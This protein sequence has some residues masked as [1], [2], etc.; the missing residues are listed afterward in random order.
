MCGIAGAFDLTGRRPFELTAL[1]RMGR[2]LRHRGPD[3]AGEWAEGG[4]ALAARRLAVVDAAGGHQP[5]S[6]P[7]QRIWVAFN[8][9][10]FNA[11]EL[12]GEL[13]SKGHAFH[14]RCDTEL[15]PAMYLEW[16][17]AMVERA[18]GQFA[19]ALFD[20]RDRTLL[21]LRDR[22]GVCPLHHALADGWLLFAS[23]AKAILAS[24]LVKPAADLRGIDP[25]FSLFA[26]STVRTCFDGIRTLSPGHVLTAREGKATWRRY[27][28]LSFPDAGS[29][30]RTGPIL[31]ELGEALRDAVKRRLVA[32]AP[33]GAYLSGGLDSTLLLGLSRARQAFTVG[34][35][36]GAGPDE[37]AAA[38]L[39]ARG[40]GSQLEEVAVTPER[41][42]EAIPRAV[43]AA[44]G[45]LMDTANAAALLLAEAVKARGFKAVITGEGAD[46]AMGGYLWSRLPPLP[47]WLRRS[48]GALLVPGSTEA[49][50]GV[51]GASLLD[52]YAVLS[53]GR[54]RFYSAA[55]EE[56]LRG[57]D[58][59]DAFDLSREQ[60][61]RWH[62]LHR[63]LY[64]EYKVMLPGHLLAGKGDRVAMGSGVE[65]RYPFLD[66]RVVELC[67]SLAP[68]FKVRGNRGKW[69]LRELARG[70]LPP[71]LADPPKRMFK[72]LPLAE[73]KPWPTWVKQLLSPPSLRATGYFD[74]A[75]VARELKAPAWAPRRVVTDG[76]LTAVITT[77]L[78]HHLYLG[79]GLCELPRWSAG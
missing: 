25:A 14:T 36:D 42:L 61:G 37:R 21:L 10:L 16:G 30:R 76:T 77:Q 71:E 34:F 58:P 31:E 12:R 15:W 27:W 6:D 35:E 67:A 52:V 38:R 75:K 20:R 64:L 60:L 74:D 23:E 29:E 56:A 28:E 68:E 47:R 33:V 1:A 48:L 9:E 79:G 63:G 39:A 18:R 72:A 65:T 32:D 22:I 13:Q 3:G 2:A 51:G 4:V 44:E 41:L 8:G 17:E 50:L 49:E 46:E 57:V 19:V 59:L 69:L 43:I 78:W 66:E 73:L 5:L 54:G 62:P 53:R 24:G 55:T 45:P 11:E 70:V 40:L 7:S 26:A